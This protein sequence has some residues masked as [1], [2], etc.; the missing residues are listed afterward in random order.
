[1]YCKRSK[2]EHG[3]ACMVYVQKRYM[4]KPEAEASRD[5]IK[6]GLQQGMQLISCTHKMYEIAE[7]DILRSKIVQEL[8]ST[9]LLPEIWAL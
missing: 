7:P 5:R 8:H 2:P 3:C 6:D 4:C 1:M 9:E